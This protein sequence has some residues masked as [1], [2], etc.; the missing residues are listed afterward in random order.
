LLYHELFHGKPETFYTRREFPDASGLGF[1]IQTTG[2]KKGGIL[3]I[4]IPNNRY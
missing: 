3:R 2:S 1:R 4:A